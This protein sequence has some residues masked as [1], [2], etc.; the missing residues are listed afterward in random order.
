MEILAPLSVSH[1]DD[2]AVEPTEKVDPLLA[3]GPSGVLSGEDRCIEHGI[4]ALEIQAVAAKVGTALPFVPR[5]HR[6][7]RSYRK[8]L[9]Q[10]GR[11]ATCP[12][13]RARRRL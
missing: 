5:D 2:R 1:V 10:P 6:A 12:L 7:N 9:S 3:V 11:Q 8:A 13:G 4:T